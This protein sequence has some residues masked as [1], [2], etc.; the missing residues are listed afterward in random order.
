MRRDQGVRLEPD[1]A[2]T[3]PSPESH[4]AY[5]PD[6]RQAFAS[7]LRRYGD[8]Y[9]QELVITVVGL[10]LILFFTVDS[11]DFFTTSNAAALSSFISPIAFFAL[12]EV[13]ILILGEIDLSVGQVYV[14]S[15]FIVQQLN[16]HGTPIPLAIIMSLAISAVIGWLNGLITVK[17][18]LPSFITTLGMTFALEGIV[19]IGSNGA[20]SNPVGGGILALVLGGGVWAEAYWAAAVMF[21]L[22][23]ML[24]RTSFGLHIVAVGGNAESSRESGLRVDFIKIWCFVLCSFIGGLIGILDGYHIGSIDPASSGLTFMFYGVA[25]AVIGGTALTGGR[26]T[27]IGAAL[28]AIV[29]GTLED[30]FHVISVSSFA[31]DLILGIAITIAMFLNV[32]IERA[33]LRGAGRGSLARIIGFVFTPIP[34]FSSG[35]RKEPVHR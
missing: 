19:L 18:H 20:P 9:L 33:T 8:L 4:V 24:R 30:G 32:Q 16:N 29:L 17:L 31:Y 34:G 11:P 12:A 15:P 23:F 26:G 27:M 35:R 2:D 25:A 10:A 3:T 5:G 1:A 6:T 22:F 7:A 28:G 21:V 13:P 14:L